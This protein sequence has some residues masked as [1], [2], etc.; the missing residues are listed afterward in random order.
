MSFYRDR[1]Y[2]ALVERLGN[3]APIQALRRTLIS[4][5]RGTVL[6]IGAGSGVNFPYYDVSQIKRL[7]ALEPNPGMRRLAERQRRP[8]L[9][10]EFLSLPGERVPLGDASVDTVV[11]TFTLCTIPAVH[12]ALNSLARVLKQGGALLFL[13][14]SVADDIRVR[15]WQERWQPVHHRV[16]DGLFLTRD[17]PSLVASAGFRIEQLNAGYLSRFPKSWSHC[18]WGTAIRS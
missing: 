12:E 6:E 14:N 4:E 13:E 16:F 3:P 17:I 2:P 8:G 9:E 5:A 10:V 11:S 15:R 18:S 7:Y 1:V